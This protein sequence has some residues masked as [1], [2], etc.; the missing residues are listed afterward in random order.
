MW[1][2]S[3]LHDAQA[4]RYLAVK[5]NSDRIVLGS[6]DSFPPADH[7]PLGSLE[8][9]GFDAGEIRRITQDNPRE[10]FRL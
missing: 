7:D 5:V 9:A 2:D 3:L 10:L 4:L 6:D 1:Y 8:V